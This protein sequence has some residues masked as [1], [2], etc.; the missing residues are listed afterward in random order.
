MK[1]FEEYFNTKLKDN[2]KILWCGKPK[3]GITLKYVDLILIPMSLILLGF[4]LF[5]DYML[6]TYEN[7]SPVYIPLG[8]LLTVT[9]VYMVFVRFYVN[10][11]RRKNILYCLTDKRILR[12]AGRKLN[13]F[14]SIHLHNIVSLDKI[15]D[16]DG[17]GLILF[18]TSNPL[19]PWLLGTFRFSTG[20]FPGM[21][22]IADV[23][24]V[25]E[26]INT[27]IQL[28]PDEAGE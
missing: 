21:E 26:K 8:V 4:T 20:T 18:G 27:A 2:E 19:F 28:V 6:L 14:Q 22:S 16:K 12:L 15:S 5:F 13:K 3:S 9:T 11:E 23:E 1:P 7:V 10:T 17:S 24:N 25:Y